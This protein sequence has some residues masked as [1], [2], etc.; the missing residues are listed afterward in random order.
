[1]RFCRLRLFGISLLL[2]FMF[3]LAAPDLRAAIEGVSIL[4]IINAQLTTPGGVAITGTTN[5][6][7]AAD[8]LIIGLSHNSSANAN[9][10]GFANA[11]TSKPASPLSSAMDTLVADTGAGDG[12]RGENNFT[13]F[14]Y[15]GS[16]PTGAGDTF[17]QGAIV[18][19][20]SDPAEPFGVT[21]QTVAE[22][23][24][25][26]DPLVSQTADANGTVQA[27]A[28][29]RLIPAANLDVVLT[30][31][32]QQLLKATSTPVPPGF[33]ASANSAWSLTITNPDGSDAL[34]W[35]PDGS[36]GALPGS[37]GGTETSDPFDLT[38]NVSAGPGVDTV[39]DNLAG[40]VFRATVTLLAGVQY[41]FDIGHRS[42]AQ[43]I[44]SG[45]IP[46]PASVA[47]WGGLVALCL[48]GR[49]RRIAID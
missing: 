2:M 41:Q 12:L 1:M 37:L 5:P 15:A 20:V 22:A 34:V 40:G 33:F 16:E 43:V 32:A 8:V 14:N 27:G 6:A 25:S 39:I 26:S 46:E 3:G 13:N 24:V 30:F 23:E 47:V 36:V 9:A 4:N 38:R 10:S 44:T 17:G 29:F 45:V 19:L 11:S 21:A 35:A 48:Y 7:L 18:D 49:R 42:S 28:S 31:T